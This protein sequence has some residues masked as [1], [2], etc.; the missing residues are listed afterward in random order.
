MG[1]LGGIKKT[2][3]WGG[4]AADPRRV[5]VDLDSPPVG[6]APSSE[7]GGFRVLGFRA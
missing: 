7:L 5:G 6:T 3:P 4:A 1:L 2:F